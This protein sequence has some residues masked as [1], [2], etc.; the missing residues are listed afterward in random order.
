MHLRRSGQQVSFIYRF[1][2]WVYIEL[3]TLCLMLTSLFAGGTSA[4]ILFWSFDRGPDADFYRGV[5]DFVTE[6]HLIVAVGLIYIAS[7]L[8]LWIS[9]LVLFCEVIWFVFVKK[10]IAR[11]LPRRP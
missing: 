11:S 1:P 2:Q 7:A 8:V 6:Y 3:A 4:R 5:Y 10:R 9:F